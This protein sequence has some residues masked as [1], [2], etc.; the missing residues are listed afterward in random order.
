MNPFQMLGSVSGIAVI[1]LDSARVPG[2]FQIMANKADHLDWAEG[3]VEVAERL[4]E[5]NDPVERRWSAVVAYYAILQTAHAVAADMWN[6]HPQ[7]HFEVRNVVLRIDPNRRGL[8]ASIQEAGTISN[9][10][11]YIGDHQS[12]TTWFAPYFTSE[13]EAIERALELMRTVVPE[14]RRIAWG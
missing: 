12:A 7:D 6:E 14:L 3:N 10:A 11:R 4:G 5:S 13:D 1:G 2:Y 8:A 9:G